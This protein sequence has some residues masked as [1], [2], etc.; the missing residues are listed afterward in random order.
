MYVGMWKCTSFPLSY[1]HI[2]P[3]LYMKTGAPA[4]RAVAARGGHRPLLRRLQ[5]LY[6]GVYIFFSS[7]CMRAVCLLTC[8][9]LNRC[10]SG[11]QSSCMSVCVCMCPS[12]C[13]PVCENKTVHNHNHTHTLSSPPK[14]HTL[15]LPHTPQNN[16][17]SP[18]R[19]S[20]PPS[21]GAWGGRD[22][23]K[24]T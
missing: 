11:S 21:C 14:T 12:L 20:G 18:S 6:V 13:A 1:S 23:P 24:T 10:V 9:S 15:S 3:F 5:G 4:V 19:N 2:S 16:R 17:P 7:L 22:P 8:V